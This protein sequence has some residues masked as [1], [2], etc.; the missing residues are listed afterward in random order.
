M[1]APKGQ[2]QPRDDK[3]LLP[4]ITEDEGVEPYEDEDYLR[5]VPPHH[6]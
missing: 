1:S 3:P 6:G 4:D 2:A 5:E